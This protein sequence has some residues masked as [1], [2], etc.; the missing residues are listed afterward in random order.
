MLSA[1]V[2]AAG[3]GACASYDLSPSEV[4][5]GA[6]PLR[7]D[8]IRETFART[9]TLKDAFPGNDGLRHEVRPDGRW[10]VRT[11]LLVNPTGAW[12]VDGD[13]LC[14]N[15]RMREDCAPVYRIDDGRLYAAF[16]GWSREHST[17][18]IER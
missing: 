4:P 1:I 17:L 8:E 16:D 14:L 12:R 13:R 11:G 7:G 6:R 18:R 10:T 2:L 5:P 3:L 15:L 9:V